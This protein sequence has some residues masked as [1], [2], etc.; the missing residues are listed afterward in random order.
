MAEADYQLRSKATSSRYISNSEKA[1]TTKESNREEKLDS[2]IKIPTPSTALRVG[3]VAYTAKRV[4]HLL[5]ALAKI[6]PYSFSF[7]FD[8]LS[9]I[10][11][12]MSP[13]APRRRFHCS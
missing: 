3:S 1:S 4:G 9:S 13:A 2:E 6:Q 12:L 10:N 7:S 11:C 5:S 8:L